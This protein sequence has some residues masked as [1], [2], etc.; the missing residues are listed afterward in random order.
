MLGC[1]PYINETSVGRKNKNQ[2]VVPLAP[3]AICAIEFVWVISGGAGGMG[4]MEMKHYQ[5]NN[6]SFSPRRGINVQ[7]WPRVLINA[8]AP[9]AYIYYRRFNWPC[10]HVVINLPHD[11]SRRHNNKKCSKETIVRYTAMKYCPF[12]R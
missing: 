6:P 2:Q 8:H 3:G 5:M 11:A 10:S 9:S 12:E 7:F 1:R 4:S